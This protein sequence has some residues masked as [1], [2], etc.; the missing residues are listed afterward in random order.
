[1][2]EHPLKHV[3]RLQKEGKQ[4]GIYSACTSSEIVLRAC[5]ERAK[6]TS[7]VLLIEATANQVDQYG[8]YTGMK[9]A[10]FMK[11]IQRLAGEEG[12]PMS[13]I[14]LGGDHL[15][16]LTFTRY[17]EDKAMA[18]AR[19]LI[20]QFVLAGFTKI[21]L[22]TSMKVASDD[23]DTRLSDEV[24]SRRGAEL[25][26][27]AEDSYKELL[28]TNPNAVH[29][30]Y[31]VGSEVP[32][33][34]GSQQS[35]DTGLQVT[36]VEDFKNT[37]SIFEK[38]FHEHGLDEAWNQV[39]GFVV[40]PG[41]E[42]KDAGCTPYDRSKAV[43][44]MA[45][46]K[47]YP[48]FV[49]EGH[50]TDYQ[51]KYALRELVE[52]GVGI[53]KVGPGLSFAAREGLFALAYA[54]KEVFADQP[55]KQSHFMEVLDAAMV[56]NPVYYQKHYHGTPAE[57]AY[58]RKF[59]FS[60]RSRY[61]MPTEEVRKAQE[62]LFN[63]FKDGV[64]LGVLSQFMPLEYTKVREGRLHNDPLSLVKDRVIYTVDEYLY[65]SHQNEIKF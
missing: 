25:A 10:D 8:G 7:S 43:D 16:P 27:V 61:Y 57:I 32:I 60:D 59:S 55:E 30:V 33:P 6:E 39:V 18:E 40:Q 11:F 3:V 15:G 34:G 36:K 47:E 42:E 21:H 35:V 29:P 50:S 31:I 56:A 49:F 63:N 2:N 53:L 51:T 13:Q 5:M 65:A 37:V 28:K 20:R 26:Q 17:N 46:I 52:D 12:I 9:P 23:P 14:I 48:N 4:V 44:L 38:S 54:E 62:V 41:V 64:P 24:I 45:S 19:E 1:M 58:R 22:D